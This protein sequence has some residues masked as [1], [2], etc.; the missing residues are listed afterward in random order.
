MKEVIQNPAAWDAV[1]AAYDDRAR[2]RLEP[3]SAAAIEWAQLGPRDDALD[4]ACGP[5]TT[6]FLLAPRVRSVFALDFSPGMIEVLQARAAK[7]SNVTAAVGDGHA[8]ALSSDRFSAAFSMFGLVFFREPV[9]ALRE[10][11]R[12]LRPGGQVFISCWAPFHESPMM[13]P[14][15]EAVRIANPPDPDAPPPPPL[16]WDSAEL[17]AGGL[18]EAGFTEVEVRALAFE[19]EVRDGDDYWADAD[20]NI[21]V[22]H[23]RAQKGEAWPALE[24]KIVAHLR[25]RL[26]GGAR[27]A[28]PGFLGRGVKPIRAGR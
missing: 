11:Y 14:L 21:F 4:V 26:R 7:L 1:A 27:L 6:T 12:V 8:L 18:R 9:A 10:L 24:A 3:Y 20:A 22:D 13:Q 28:M 23:L 15:F 25:A 16:A 5:G 19:Q 2:A 17:L